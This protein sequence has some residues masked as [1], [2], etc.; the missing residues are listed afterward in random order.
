MSDQPK[1]V[2]ELIGDDRHFDDLM[3][4][5][6]EAGVAK[7]PGVKLGLPMSPAKWAEVLK[8]IKDN[9]MTEERIMREYLAGKTVGVT[10]ER[11]SVRNE[12][13]AMAGNA[14]VNKRDDEARMLRDLALKLAP[15]G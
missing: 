10:Q 13:N 14:F 8:F 7:E 15:K 3:R 5:L 11:D 2:E 4:H 9:L 6:Y 1:A 12:L